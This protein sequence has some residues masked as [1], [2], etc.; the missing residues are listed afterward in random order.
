MEFFKLNKPLRRWS[1]KK[2]ENL[3]VKKQKV[4]KYKDGSQVLWDFIDQWQTQ[5][6]ESRRF[7]KEPPSL[8]DGFY[9]KSGEKNYKL[10][11]L[12]E[13]FNAQFGINHGS[14]FGIRAIQI[15]Q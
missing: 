1:I 13:T 11:A 4:K 3:K 6:W 2:M 15:T 12:C 7:D 14:I 9:F 5:I 10:V 8:I